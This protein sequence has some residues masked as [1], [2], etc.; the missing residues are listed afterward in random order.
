MVFSCVRMAIGNDRLTLR[1]LVGSVEKVGFDP[2]STLWAVAAFPDVLNDVVAPWQD[3]NAED[4][5]PILAEDAGVLETIRYAFECVVGFFENI[6]AALKSLLNTIIGIIKVIFQGII[7]LLSL[8]ADV[9]CFVLEVFFMVCNL[10]FGTSLP[11]DV[12]IDLGALVDAI[13]EVRPTVD[14]NGNLIR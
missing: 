7:F 6:F 5:Y 2:I 9:V 4:F 11:L 1:E 13:P 3:W 10:C 14:A 8:I 12:S